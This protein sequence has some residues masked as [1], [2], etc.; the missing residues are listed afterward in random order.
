MIVDL[1]VKFAKENPTWGFDRIQG[2]VAKVGYK[3]TDTT[4]ANILKAHVHYHTARCH[5]GRG[6]KLI[7][8]LWHIRRT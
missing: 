1:T 6:N 7:V 4:V 5:Q 2:E 8:P 3:I